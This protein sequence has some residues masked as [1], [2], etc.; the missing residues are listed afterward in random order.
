MFSSSQSRYL[1]TSL[2][3]FIQ[4]PIRP[5]IVRTSHPL[6]CLH[7]TRVHLMHLTSTYHPFTSRHISLRLCLPISSAGLSVSLSRHSLPLSPYPSIHLPTHP[8]S[9]RPTY[10]CS[11]TCASSTLPRPQNYNC[12]KLSASLSPLLTQTFERG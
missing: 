8:T 9:H 5:P 2:S 6:I 7:H 1:S 11:Q 4:P 10:K 3:D 12:L